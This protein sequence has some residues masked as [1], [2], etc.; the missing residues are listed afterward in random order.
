MGRHPCNSCG[1]EGWDYS[2]QLSEICHNGICTYWDGI[3][4]C[5]ECMVY[6]DCER[7]GLSG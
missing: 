3:D 2:Q 1:K 7:C 6:V 5:P 4:I